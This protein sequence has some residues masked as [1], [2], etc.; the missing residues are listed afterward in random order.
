MSDKKDFRERSRATFDKCGDW[1]KK[2]AGD[3]ADLV[4]DGCTDWEVTFSWSAGFDEPN[5]PRINININKLDRDIINACLGL[6][7]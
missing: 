1:F 5:V 2:N 6:D 4:A 3:L 7:G